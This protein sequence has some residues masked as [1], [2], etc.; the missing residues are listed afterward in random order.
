MMLGTSHWQ[1]L[2]GWSSLAETERLLE[3]AETL[4]D[5]SGH[6]ITRAA[7]RSDLKVLAG[8]LTVC[9]FAICTTVTHRGFL[10]LFNQR[11]WPV[12]ASVFVGVMNIAH[13]G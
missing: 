10:P 7:I 6:V 13:Y 8:S 4:R 9:E 1:R 5:H 11:G 3:K 2:K 12:E